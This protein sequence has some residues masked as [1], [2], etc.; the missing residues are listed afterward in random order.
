MHRGMLLLNLYALHDRKLRP[1]SDETLD[2]EL[3][4][5]LVGPPATLANP[6]MITALNRLFEKQAQWNFVL[7][8]IGPRSSGARAGSVVANRMN[9]SEKRRDMPYH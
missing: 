8:D 1:L 3:F 9:T 4:V 2:H 7:N 5:A 6:I